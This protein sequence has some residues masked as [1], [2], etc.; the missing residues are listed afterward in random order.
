MTKR[1]D[2]I[3]FRRGTAAEWT[4]SEPQPGGEILRL[5]EPGYEKDTGKLKIGDGVTP[6]NSLPYMSAGT[7]VIEDVDGL[8]SEILQAGSGIDLNFN[9][10]TDS[11]TV[12]VSGLINNPTNNRILTSR[13]DTSIGIDAESNLTFDG[14][15]LAVSGALVIDKIKIDDNV[16]YAQTPTNNKHYLGISV[17]QLIIDTSEYSAA[18]DSGGVTI[19]G[20]NNPTLVITN[21]ESSNYPTEIKLRSGGGGLSNKLI[22]GS[23]NTENYNGN[24]PSSNVNE[25]YSLA[26]YDLSIL[27]ESGSL[28]LNALNNSVNIGPILNVD[29]L[30]LDSNTISSTN[31]NG[32]III[33]PSG[34]GA[35]Q[36]DSG[37]DARGEYAVDWQTVRSNNNQAASGNYSVIG[38]GRSNTSSGTDST[39]AG[40]RS[41]SSSG[42]F[43]TVAGGRSNTSSGNYS[44]VGGGYSNS[45]SGY[46][47]TVA[48]GSSNSSSGYSSTVGGG[49]SNSSSGYYSTVAGGRSNSSSGTDSTVA[50]GRSNSSSGDYSTVGGGR[51]NTSSGN[52]ST[53]AGGRSNTSSGYSS[54]VGGGY[55][56]SSSGNYSTVGGGRS[57]TS[58]S[59]YS[60]VGGGYQN[61][62]S[63][64]NY[65]TVGGGR[66]NT[67]SGNY[68]TV[69]GGGRNPSSSNNSTTGGGK[70]QQ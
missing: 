21:E 30:R 43:S 8:V 64:G 29:N 10:S 70:K 16:I 3:K 20:T 56:N 67:S 38:G 42:N 36:R 13:D 63:S 59:N 28:N 5:G 65:S 15:T 33:S 54:T 2:T 19:F 69:G 24:G 39:V 7:I 48:G 40:G 50:G 35:L 66:Y 6:W 32:N 47:S 58:S 27:A 52:Y 4:A 26:D 53:V 62:S 31:T 55:N 14:T 12:S 34:A 18:A 44:T 22:I 57:N 60:T 41:N 23:Y 61:T 46:S 37:G 68:S 11:L 45:S 9:D 17:D 25:I 1:Y 51:Y 49:Y